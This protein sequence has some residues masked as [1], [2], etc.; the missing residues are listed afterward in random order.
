MVAAGA[1]CELL[2]AAEVARRFP[3]VAVPGPALYEPGSSVINASAALESLGAAPPD[4]RPHTPVTR[5]TDDGRRATIHTHEHPL[6]C[7]AAILCA[8]P[9]TARLLS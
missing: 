1:P 9:W 5:I 4:V 2:P 3:V 6:T 8:G 7:R